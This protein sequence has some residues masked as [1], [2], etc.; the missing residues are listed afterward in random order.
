MQFQHI[1]FDLDG[2]LIDSSASILTAFK[3]AFSQA[4]MQTVKPLVPEIIGP[5]LKETLK[6]LLGEDDS[7][8]IAML[9]TLF[10]EQYDILGYKKTSVFEGVE[11]LLKTLS[12]TKI[13]LY[14]ATNKRMK[15]TLLILEY[16]GWRGY[17]SGVYALDMP[18]AQSK[19]KTDLIAYVLK[20]HAIQPV[21]AI[22]I[23]DRKEDKRAAL[24][25]NLNFCYA[26][27]G[28]DAEADSDK[29]IL[30]FENPKALLSYLSA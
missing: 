26:N 6:I 18:E 3:G 2:T 24:A 11:H 10:K 28:Y 14:I 16:L 27:W 30:G 5:P 20:T 1:L 4:N 8:K 12:E 17:F 19:S 21:E 9:A 15:P 22:Y 25:N 7:E 23:G 13:P 29:T